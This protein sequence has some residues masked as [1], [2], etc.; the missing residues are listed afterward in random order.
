MTDR[1]L[2]SGNTGKVRI[3]HLVNNAL[4]VPQEATFEIQDKVFVFVMNDSNKVASRPIIVAGKT[5]SLL[6]C[7][8]WCAGR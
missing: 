1:L 7:R 2:R 3:P 6:F 5:A 4:V 8:K